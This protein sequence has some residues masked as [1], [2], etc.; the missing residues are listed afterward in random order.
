V[1]PRSCFIF[2][3]FPGPSHPSNARSGSERGSRR[4]RR[5]PIG[6]PN[7]EPVQMETLVLI[8][9]V[10]MVPGLLTYLRSDA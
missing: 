10:L 5:N 9:L 6:R 8:L 4:F 1:P 3:R 7:V 2:G